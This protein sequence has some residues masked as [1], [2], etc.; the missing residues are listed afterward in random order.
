MTKEH[1]DA[2]L[3]DHMAIELD[4]SSVNFGSMADMAEYA[5]VPE[6]GLKIEEALSVGFKAMA[7]ARYAYADAMLAERNKGSIE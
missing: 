7:K 1:K 2:T 3:R 4:I 6:P 5:G